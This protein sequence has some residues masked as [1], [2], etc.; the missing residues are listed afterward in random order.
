MTPPLV[1]IVVRTRNRPLGLREALGS[2]AAQTHPRLEAVVVND[3]GCPVRAIVEEV[4]G[5]E[6]GAA[7]A[8][9]A[10][11]LIEWPDNRGRERAGNAGLAAARGEYLGF[12]DDDDVLYPQHLAVLMAHLAGHPEDRVA[13]TDA[14]QADQVADADAPSGYRTVG[15]RLA[16]SWD[17]NP[18]EFRHQNF[19]PLHCVLFHRSCLAAVGGFDEDL[20][21]LE[22]WDFLLRLS[23]AFPMRHL[24]VVTGEYRY[25]S[26]HPRIAD[27]RGF[28]S[29]PD[30]FAARARIQA[31][32]PGRDTLAPP[33]PGHETFAQPVPEPRS[34]APEPPGG[35]VAP[36]PPE[37]ARWGR[38]RVWWRHLRRA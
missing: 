37:G 16:L 35:P 38:V 34:R 12:L 25:R 32:E 17:V 3:G 13:Y 9:I 14:F 4:L 20:R 1:S 8:G 11:T 7:S 24:R 2:L 31:K 27:P 23:W 6:A 15:R 30:L 36:A 22:D 21:R 10:W 18:A 19:I 33:F 29:T 28:A 5:G 26:D